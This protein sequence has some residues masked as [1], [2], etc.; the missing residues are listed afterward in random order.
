[1]VIIDHKMRGT[2]KELLQLPWLKGE[3]FIDF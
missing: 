2:A 1:M 3:N